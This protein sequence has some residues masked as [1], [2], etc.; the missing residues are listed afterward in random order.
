MPGNGTTRVVLVIEVARTWPS[1]TPLRVKLTAGNPKPKLAKPFPVRVKLAGGEARS[2]GL[3]VI[4]LTLVVNPVTVTEA[5][6]PPVKVT[7]LAK[8]PA[9]VGAN[10]TVTV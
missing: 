6:A 8:V 3:G 7:L 4:E 9:D 10:R 2:T 1:L 5:P